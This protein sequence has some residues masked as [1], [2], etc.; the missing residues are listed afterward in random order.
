MAHIPPR[1]LQGQLL[2]VD[3]L[4]GQDLRPRHQALQPTTH[5]GIG[6]RAG[7]ADPAAYEPA[8]RQEGRPDQVPERPPQRHHGTVCTRARNTSRIDSP[9]ALLWETGTPTCCVSSSPCCERPRTLLLPRLRCWKCWMH[10]CG[11]STTSL[12][13]IR[14]RCGRKCGAEEC[15][16]RCEPL[17]LVP[18]T[19]CHLTDQCRGSQMSS[20]IKGK[21]DGDIRQILMLE[22]R[23]GLYPITISFLNLLYTLLSYARKWQLP[24]TPVQ[25]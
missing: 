6:D 18:V 22:Q 11:A 13:A 25:H 20:S 9:S 23:N 10:A 12:P 7:Y 16:K 14:F 5:I 4:H 15:C 21:P 3:L 19:Q 17:S 8:F 1:I 2:W 24:G